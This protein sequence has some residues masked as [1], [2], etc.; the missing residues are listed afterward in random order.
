M[1]KEEMVH[2]LPVIDD[3]NKLCGRVHHRQAKTH[4][5]PRSSEDDAMKPL[6]LV[7][8]DLCGPIMPPMPGGKSSFLLL[9]DDMNRFM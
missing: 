3:V 4:V 8:G 2:E 1:G 7:H 9:V 6:G 5:I